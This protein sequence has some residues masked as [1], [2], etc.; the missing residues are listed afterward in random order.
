MGERPPQ[1]GLTNAPQNME[2]NN[3]TSDEFPRGTGDRSSLNYG[4]AT[5]IME[6]IP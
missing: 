3:H 4:I 2:S 5:Q 1:G 6:K